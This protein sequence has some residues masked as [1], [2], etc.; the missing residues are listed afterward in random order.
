WTSTTGGDLGL[1]RSTARILSPDWSRGKL[2]RYAGS[3]AGNISPGPRVSRRPN[4]I[5]RSDQFN[6]S[7]EKLA[8]QSDSEGNVGELWFSGAAV[9]ERKHRPCPG[10]R[11]RRPIQSFMRMP[12]AVAIA[13]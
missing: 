13:I 9:I 7:A 12:D 4:P 2:T 11:R 5:I 3:P 8:D 6:F 1:P 10:I